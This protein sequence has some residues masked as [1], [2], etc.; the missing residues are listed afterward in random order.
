VVRTLLFHCREHGFL[1]WWGIKMQQALR[2]RK[3]KKKVL[4]VEI[5]L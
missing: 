4:G 1:P 2:Q 3:K 5:R